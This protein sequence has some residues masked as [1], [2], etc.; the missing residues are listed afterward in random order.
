MYKRRNMVKMPAISRE[1]FPLFLH[2][3][4]ACLLY[5]ITFRISAWYR[6]S[7]EFLQQR[8]DA[9]SPLL[10]AAV[11]SAARSGD[12]SAQLMKNQFSQL[13]TRSSEEYYVDEW[14]AIEFTSLDEHWAHF[15]PQFRDPGLRYVMSIVAVVLV[16]CS[17]CV[18]F[19]ITVNIV[20][21]HDS[22]HQG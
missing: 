8:V 2:S 18:S 21:N 13:G 14:N 17:M 20:L 15:L 10:K 1:S 11:Q 3:V 4:L 9:T 7:A 6:L 16:M 22:A 5:I 19:S 12:F